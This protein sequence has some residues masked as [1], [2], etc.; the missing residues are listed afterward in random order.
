MKSPMWLSFLLLLSFSACGEKMNF[1][2]RLIYGAQRIYSLELSNGEFTRIKD[3]PD[4]SVDQIDKINEHSLLVSS[5]YL[6]PTKESRRKIAIYDFQSNA[7][8]FILVGSRGV[9]I[10]AYEKI[11]FYDRKEHLSIADIDGDSELI[12]VIDTYSTTYPMPVVPVSRSEFI[13]ESKRNGSRG[14]WKYSFES[15]ESTELAGLKNCALN[16]AVWRSSTS[17]LLCFEI[18]ENG[19]YTGRYFFIDLTGG[20]RQDI[21]F[22][23]GNFAPVIYIDSLDAI[24]LQERAASLLKGEFHPVYIYKFAEGLKIKISENNYLNRRVAYIES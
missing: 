10:P 5:Y 14:I 13:Y 24:V 7:L 4:L 1:K 21:S 23:K 15:G 17:E 9:Y 18:L 11:V 16:N 3:V 2:G 20:E 6:K 12:E 22:G 19:Q 8:K